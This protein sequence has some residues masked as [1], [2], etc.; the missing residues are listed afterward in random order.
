M[1]LN[2]TPQVMVDEE[3]SNMSDKATEEFDK[4]V[5]K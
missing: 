1:D 4:L 3:V 5:I 2:P